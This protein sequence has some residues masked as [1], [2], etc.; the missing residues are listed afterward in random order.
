[1]QLASLALSNFKGVNATMMLDK[2]NLLVGPNG[3]GKTARLLAQTWGITG[4]TSLGGRPED[5][6]K[7]GGTRGCRVILTTDTGFG[8]MRSLQVDHRSKKLSTAV[9]VTG[10]ESLGVT[11]GHAIVRQTVGDYA[12][13][14]D[15]NKFLDLSAEGKRQ[16][17]LNLCARAIPT[18]SDE[19]RKLYNR[20]LTEWL[21]QELGEGTVAMAVKLDGT[22]K[23]LDVLFMTVGGTRRQ[24]FNDVMQMVCEG[25]RVESAVEAIATSLDTAKNMMNAAKR[26]RDESQQAARKLSEEKAKVEVPAEVVEELTAKRNT[27]VD[28]RTEI[29]TQ[30]ANQR[31][32]ESARTSLSTS[33]KDADWKLE[34]AEKRLAG[35]KAATVAPLDEAE[36]LEKLAAQIDIQEYDSQ[37]AIDKAAAA[38][39]D[40]FREEEGLHEAERE[41]D[42]AVD[43]R[44]MSAQRLSEATHSP[45]QRALALATPL[46]DEIRL[47]TGESSQRTA[48]Q[49]IYTIIVEQAQVA[50]IQELE[51]QFNVTVGR[52]VELEEKVSVLTRS[53]AHAESQELLH[54]EEATKIRLLER[55]AQANRGQRAELLERA[56]TIR[57]ASSRREHEIKQASKDIE[58]I[59]KHRVS[60]ERR[61]N[62]LDAEG[63]H[64]SL[65]DLDEQC[66]A[67]DRELVDLNDKIKRKQQYQ[68]LEAE[69]TKCIASAEREGIVH[70]V[71]KVV[72]EAIR[73]VRETMMREVVAPLIERMDE[74]LG[75][76][77][78]PASGVYCDLVNPRG[79]SIFELGWIVDGE[80]KVPV[81]AMSGGESV[82]FS[83][84]LLLA[85]IELADPPLKLLLIEA[86]ALDNERLDGLLRAI[87]SVKD[88]FSN[89]F[90]A[91]HG[92]FSEISTD[93]NVVHLGAPETAEATA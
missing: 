13:M 32:R 63:G 43:N 69:L 88:R 50:P 77:G 66:L 64:M 55:D 5:T 60:V 78:V 44:A 62:E 75:H 4:Q 36:R 22:P 1:M 89:A 46:N 81:E 37:P 7:L 61:L 49:A 11:E 17:V 74:C 68:T 71:C 16:E 90:V 51:E 20:I 91:T 84:C 72:C 47:V 58:D 67:L 57:E 6:A 29:V 25:S 12:P 86:G 35:A 53:A 48:W 33:L 93:W 9:V 70:S 21:K 10:K 15:V 34:T 24:A 54:E 41:L 85:L 26:Q 80:R 82:L 65:D 38:R 19:P 79:R 45:W 18:P 73:T 27:L 87:E 76:M 39:S 2:L 83:T 30:I 14:F 42:K 23:G 92:E 3:S 52:E 59:Q 31:G 56:K 8:W 40:K 28:R